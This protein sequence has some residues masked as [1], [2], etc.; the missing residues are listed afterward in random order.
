MLPSSASAQN[1]VSPYDLIAAMNASRTANGYT[2]LVIDQSIMISAQQTAEQMAAQRL[3]GHIGNVSQRVCAAGYN[4]GYGC[5]ATENWVAVKSPVSVNRIM[6]SWNDPA[7][8]LPANNPSYQHVGAGAAVAAD[9]TIYYVLQAAYPAGSGGNVYE[10]KGKEINEYRE[11]VMPVTVVPVET[12]L[13]DKDGY[14]FH[15]VQS[16]QTIWAIAQAYDVNADDLAAWNRVTD[17]T[18][19]Y[20]D[21]KLLIP[22]DVERRPTPT[23]DMTPFPT[24]SPDG[25]FRCVVE[26]GDTIWSIAQK[27]GVREAD[28]LA[29]NGLNHDTVIGVGWKLFVPVT[30]TP[31][32]VPT[33]VPTATEMFRLPYTEKTEKEEA[34]AQQLPESKDTAGWL[35]PLGIT[36]FLSLSGLLAMLIMTEKNRDRKL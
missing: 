1:G 4:N 32:S 13:P 17:S 10:G 18:M 6:A 24:M 3:N 16:G 14:L 22:F 34:A 27:W 15:K 29:V 19:L 5:Q 33:A 11:Y 25:K 9:G 20:P 28:L 7:H 21:Q 30:P 12:A 31:T 23:P 2:A 8:M 36:I 26:E 35:I